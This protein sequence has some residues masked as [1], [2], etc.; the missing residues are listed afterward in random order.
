MAVVLNQNSNT[1]QTETPN[2][3]EDAKK[4]LDICRIYADESI[5]KQIM[6]DEL[7]A[8]KTTTETGN[9]KEYSNANIAGREYPVIRIGEF[10]PSPSQIA[11]LRIDSFGRIPT[12]SLKLTLLSDNFRSKNMPTDGDIISLFMAP[13]SGSLSSIRCDFVINSV[14]Q[15]NTSKGI[16]VTLSGELFI[17]G[18]DTDNMFG[19][20]GTSKTAFIETAK[21]FGLGFATDDDEDTNDKQMWICYNIPCEEYLN[22]VISHSWKDETSF[23]DW[24]IDEHYNINFINVNKMLLTNTKEFDITAASGV[25]GADYDSPVDYSQ[26]N[27]VPINKVF[28]NLPEYSGGVFFVKDWHVTNNSSA[29]SM[30]EGV[31]IKSN[32]FRH[33]DNIYMNGDTPVVTL[34]N[35]PA[36]DQNKLKNHI[37]LRGRAKYDPSKSPEGVQARANYNFKDIYIKKPWCGISYVMNDEDSNSDDNNTWSGNINKNYIR[38]E[39]HNKINLSELDKMYIEILVDGLCTQVMR[40]EVVPVGLKKSEGTQ[41]T[42][43]YDEQSG[44]ADRFFTGFYYV[45]GITYEFVA[46]NPCHYQTRF[47]LTRREWPIPVDYKEDNNQINN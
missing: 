7:S 10:I 36:Y 2:N 21:K 33:N 8:P 20:I 30:E 15:K 27:T 1:P 46:G 37:I 9:D 44:R 13:K 24:W 3:I 39:Y 26:K 22:Q 4:N 23:Y 17:P 19:T 12:I 16:D 32:E 40:G 42:E 6:L 41:T 31:E 35:V 47:K 38:A 11:K 34:S 28:T 25:I 18:F 29:I 43:K 14:S 45:Q 5:E